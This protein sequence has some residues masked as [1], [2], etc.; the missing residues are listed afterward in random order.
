[1]SRR[2]L[3]DT[4]ALSDF[5]NHRRGVRER[6]FRMIRLGYRIGTTPPVISELMDGICRSQS[7]E[8]NRQR[9]R[10]GLTRLTVWPSDLVAADEFG[11]LS[12]ELTRIG[13]P[14]QTVD[15]QLAAVALILGCTVVTTDSDLSAVPGLSVENWASPP[16]PASA[17]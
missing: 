4:N 10:H 6:A 12:A 17:S 15:I 2:F 11:R 7:E 13:R 5:I 3:L 1:M 9:A 8:Y 14:M 16:P